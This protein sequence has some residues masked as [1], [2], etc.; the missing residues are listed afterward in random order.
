MIH[1]IIGG[2]GLPEML[3]ISF[4][5]LL[6][7]GGK[8]IPGLMKGIG[9]GIAEFTK[10]KKSVQNEFLKPLEEDLQETIDDFDDSVRA[11]KRT[12]RVVKKLLK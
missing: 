3:V 12:G 10:A 6:L 5:L 8:K 4:V 1:L 9:Q 11:V 7:F 2:L